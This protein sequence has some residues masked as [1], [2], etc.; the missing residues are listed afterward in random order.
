MTKK[1]CTE[2]LYYLY[3]FHPV[4]VTYINDIPEIAEIMDTSTAMLR[5]DETYLTFV[6]D[7]EETEEIT[8]E[9]F[10]QYCQECVEEAKSKTQ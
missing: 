7:C 5:E 8:E 1:Q 2:T 10:K 4:K 9:Q 6:E 3:G